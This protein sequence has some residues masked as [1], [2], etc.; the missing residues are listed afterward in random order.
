MASAGTSN[1]LDVQNDWEEN[2]HT[3]VQYNGGLLPD[4]ITLFTHGY[5][6]RGNRLNTMYVEALSLQPTR[7]E[8]VYNYYYV[9]C[10]TTLFLFCFCFLFGVSIN[11]GPLPDIILLT[12]C[13]GY[14]VDVM[15]YGS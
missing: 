11:D 8:I 1:E 2:T 13:L 6:H 15:I 5:Y 14:S 12:Q 7:Y 9:G 4:I 10:C 3:S